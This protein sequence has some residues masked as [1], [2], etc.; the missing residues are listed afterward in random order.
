MLAEKRGISARRGR[1]QGAVFSFG[2]SRQRRRECRH[3]A[4][5]FDVAE[6]T[7]QPVDIRERDLF[8]ADTDYSLDF[9]LTIKEFNERIVADPDYAALLMGIGRNLLYRTGSR[10]VSREGV[11]S[12]PMQERRTAQMRA[13]PHNGVLQQLGSI[14]P[15][16]IVFTNYMLPEYQRLARSFGVEHFLNKSVDYERLPQLLLDIHAGKPH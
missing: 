13:I 1:A 10:R 2:A 6:C 5:T 12:R 15:T 3:A 8:Y 9:F 16:V 4:A 11:G 14:R 7:E